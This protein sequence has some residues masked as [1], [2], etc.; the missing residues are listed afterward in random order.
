MA[1]KFR[2]VVATRETSDRFAQHT[3]LGRSLALY[4]A[5]SI[6]LRLFPENRAGLPSVYNIAIREAASDPAVLIFAHDD[7]YIC[8]F[9]WTSHLMIALNRFDIVGLAGNKR[10]VPHQPAWAFTDT[11]WNLDNPENLSGIVGHGKGFPP[12]KLCYYGRPFQEVKLL[13]GLMLMARSEVLLSKQLGFDE[14][15]D[16][17]FY[18][19]DF[20][21]QAE[22]LALRMGTCGVSVIHESGGNFNGESWRAAY[23]SY[24][25]KWGS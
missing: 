10:R 25:Q 23:A 8:D 4:Q 15:F 6:E 21:R 5:P 24:L 12:A 7:L 13:D 14:R 20:C 3:G 1:L 19:L 9:F 16:F 18:D 11:G 22:K 17:H 2:F